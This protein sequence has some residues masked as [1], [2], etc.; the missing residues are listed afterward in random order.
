MRSIWSKRHHLSRIYHYDNW[1]W[2]TAVQ[3]V[4][5]NKKGKRKLV[6]QVK[7]WCRLGQQLTF[8]HIL[9]YVWKWK[10]MV[11]PIAQ[12]RFGRETMNN[13]RF[14]HTKKLAISLLHDIMSM[15]INGYKQKLTVRICNWS[16]RPENVYYMADVFQWGRSISEYCL[17][18]YASS[19]ET[20]IVVES[21]R[22]VIANQWF[23]PAVFARTERIAEL[24]W[25]KLH[26]SVCHV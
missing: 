5:K 9:R 25:E 6:W 12:T 20:P 26:P 2:S 16:P 15:Q 8:F 1:A 23:F 19:G 14:R 17:F 10:G 4:K 24:P 7:I 22:F 11:K 13:T 18:S 3:A 21:N